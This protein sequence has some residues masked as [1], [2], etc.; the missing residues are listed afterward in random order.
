MPASHPG[1]RPPR[2]GRAP[3]M[4]SSAPTISHEISEFE[5]HISPVP[6]SSRPQTG[7]GTRGTRS[8]TRAARARWRVSRRGG[9]TASSASGMHPPGQRRTSYR[10][11]R[12]RPA[13]RARHLDHR[14]DPVEVD[15]E[16]R[17]VEVVPRPPRDAGRDR[18]EDAAV[19]PDEVTAGAERQPQQIDRRAPRGVLWR[20]RGGH[21]A[22]HVHGTGSIPT[23]PAR[24]AV[25]GAEAMARATAIVGSAAQPSC[26]SLVDRPGPGSRRTSTPAR[27]GPG[28]RRT[29]PALPLSRKATSRAVPSGPSSV[30]RRDSGGRPPLAA[31]TRP[32]CRSACP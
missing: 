17:V 30:A 5:F 25:R 14:C 12:R 3:S 8:R 27:S 31:R 4:S 6:S 29:R 20:I 15:V 19:T 16:R 13:H 23:V 26:G 28:G 2:G 9:P 22:R 7:V 21:R 18:L 1:A 24:H 32:A 10:N 11:R